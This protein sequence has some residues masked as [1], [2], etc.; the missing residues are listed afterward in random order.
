[1][2]KYFLSQIFQPFKN[3]QSTKKLL[4]S[5]INDELKN[6]TMQNTQK[7]TFQTNGTVFCKIIDIYDGDTINI[8]MKYN[9]D[10]FSFRIRLDGI[11][12]PELKPSSAWEISFYRFRK[13]FLIKMLTFFP[14]PIHQSIKWR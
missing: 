3:K 11:D 5:K 13:K 8:A 10:I 1:M 7:F 12:S 6:C 4:K 9:N 2:S 14:Y